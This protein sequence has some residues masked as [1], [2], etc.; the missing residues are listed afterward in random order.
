MVCAHLSH[1]TLRTLSRIKDHSYNLQFSLSQVQ[2]TQKCLDYYLKPFVFCVQ[3]YDVIT[4][5]EIDPSWPNLICIYLYYFPFPLI[6]L[7]IGLAMFFCCFLTLLPWVDRSWT[8]FRSIH[9]QARGSWNYN[10]AHMR[11]TILKFYH[12]VREVLNRWC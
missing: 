12:F 5:P 9:N 4:S 8:P 7:V 6:L 10:S 1:F 2:S 3:L 11:F